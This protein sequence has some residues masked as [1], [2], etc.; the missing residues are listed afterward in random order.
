MKSRGRLL[1]VDTIVILTMVFLA[2]LPLQPVY[3]GVAV[4]IPIGGGLL[5]ATITAAITAWRRW[6]TLATIA[7]A[8]VVYVVC[9]AGLATPDS[10]FKG[11]LPSVDSTV[12]IAA[13]S[14]N[15]WTRVL[16]LVPPLG[17]GGGF[18]IAPYAL[19]FVCAMVGLTIAYRVR[20][21]RGAWAAALPLF[22]LI[23]SMVLCTSTSVYPV[24]AGLAVGLLALIW[25]SWR[26]GTLQLRRAF[27]VIVG[28]SVAA[29]AGYF[30][31]PLVGYQNGRTVVRDILIPPFDPN[32]YRSPLSAF[33]QYF[34]KW[35]NDT[36]F[37]VEGL[38][39]GASIRLATM[40]EFTGVVWNVAGGTDASGS[41]EFRRVGGEIPQDEEGDEVSV[42]FEIDKLTGVWLPTIGDETAFVFPDDESDANEELRFNDATGT[43][44]LP[45]GVSNGMSYTVDGWWQERPS[46]EEIMQADVG[47]ANLPAPN[48]VPDVVQIYASKFAGS[49]N[50]PGEIALTL[51][52]GLQEEG[53]F[54][55]GQLVEGT[56]QSPSLAGHGADRIIT[57]LTDEVMVGDAEQYASAMAL[58]ARQLGLPAR[59]VLGFTP[60]KPDKTRTNV[61]GDDVNA[62]VEIHFDDLG[63]VSFFPTP[64][65]DK[66]PQEDTTIQEPQRRPQ[67]VQPP[68]PDADPA[69][70]PDEDTELPDTHRAEDLVEPSMLLTIVVIVG[71]ALLVP[72]LLIV[73]PILVIVWR[74]RR[75]R[76]RRARQG[77]ASG[78]IA[79]GWRE[80]LDT[81][82]DLKCEIPTIAT[83]TEKAVALSSALPL[84]DA[85]QGVQVLA[86]RADAAVFDK[87]DPA[88]AE[89]RGYWDEVGSVLSAMGAGFSRWQRFR[90]RASTRSL[91]RARR[92][93]E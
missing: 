11:V 15:V 20:S 40:D 53:Y 50:S 73:L 31:G 16:T 47:N 61:T 6:T 38:P 12:E 60:E 41:G 71:A 2:L 77:D 82:T 78:R 79:G 10:A 90:A 23:V 81:A 34:K 64:D 93:D 92:V 42:D 58:M 36:L 13:G 74:K 54:S 5:A 69:D 9:G 75:R 19:A 22:A 30:A 68:L 26:H 14:I 4:F 91:R 85:G 32:D 51:E 63:W 7:A 21:P 17:N 45:S 44:A 66:A 29:G 88:E 8:L 46:D 76:K 52:Q 27:T 1:I 24:P 25:A 35:G 89:V 56:K 84:P 37:T 57:L 67:I 3:G 18:L 72:F 59:V 70:P 86:R 62:W 33:R 83:R 65:K 49:A 43:A 55:H 87:G 48:N 80:I 39:E 28:L